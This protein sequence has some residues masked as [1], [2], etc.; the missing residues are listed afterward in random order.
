MIE[1]II[2]ICLIILS[3]IVLLAYS[4]CNYRLLDFELEKIKKKLEEINNKLK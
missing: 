2:I 4:E 1:P 3:A